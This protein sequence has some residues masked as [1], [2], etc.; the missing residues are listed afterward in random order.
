MGKRFK[1]KNA[2]VTGASRGIGAAIAERLAAEGANV[3]VIARTLDKHPYLSGSLNE[4][5]DTLN[6]Y[7]SGHQKIVADI[8]DENDRLRA[9]AEA[10]TGFKGHV[11]I[12]VNNAAA[13]MYKPISDYSLKHRRLMAEM[14]MHAPVDL[15]QAVLEGMKEAGEGWILNLSSASSRLEPGPPY[16]PEETAYTIGVYG[17]TKAALNRLTNTMAVELYEHNIRVNAVQPVAAVLSEGADHMLGDTLRPDQL[18][19]M[20]AMVEAAIALCDCEKER[21]GFVYDSLALLEELDTAVMTL[22]GSRPFEGGFR[23]LPK[24]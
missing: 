20:E 11:N 7:G 2:V 21:T 4:T 14:N 8:S 24:S 6:Q 5:L 15:A 3:A 10:Q 22:D 19:S 16:R 18:E 13:A 1:N 12:L 9:I 17:A 23:P